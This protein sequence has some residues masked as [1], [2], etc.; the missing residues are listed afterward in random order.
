MK[1]VSTVAGAVLISLLTGCS[2]TPVAVAP[3]GPN[4]AGGKSYARNGQLEVFSALTS[5]TEGDNPTW[6]QHTDYTVYDQKGKTV[7]RVANEAGYYALSP[8]LVTLPPGKY[9]VQA[10]AKDY[11]SVKVPVV[12][13]PGQ[14]TR[15]HLDDAWKPANTPKTEIV[16]L[17][18]GNPVGWN[19]DEQ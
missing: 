14:I 2:S 16:S 9:I 4:P 15:V 11:L 1:Y 3:V 19:L 10:E 12:I 8:R 7:K 17:P 6:F 18:S 13:K 5:R